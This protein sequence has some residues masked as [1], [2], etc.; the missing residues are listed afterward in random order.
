MHSDDSVGVEF[1]HD[2]HDDVGR[3]PATQRLLHSASLA[4]GVP[5]AR[6]LE[7]LLYMRSAVGARFVP[8]FPGRALNSLPSARGRPLLAKEAFLLL[9][10]RAVAA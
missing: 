5:C 3:A 10:A 4:F 8:S 2:V 7:A 6:V 9:Y 1:G